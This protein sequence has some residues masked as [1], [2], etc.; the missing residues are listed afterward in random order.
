MTMSSMYT[1]QKIHKYGAK[2]TLHDPLENGGPISQAKGHSFKLEETPMCPEG[3]LFDILSI[4]LQ[5]G[6]T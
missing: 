4:H 6:E 5:L 2:N 3:C 1:R